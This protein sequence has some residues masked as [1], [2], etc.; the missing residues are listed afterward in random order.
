MIKEQL[1]VSAILT[2]CMTAGLAACTAENTAVQEDAPQ[3]LT[4]SVNTNG[5]GGQTRGTP[6]NAV[7]D[8][9]A[10]IGLFAYEY[11]DEDMDWDE[12]RENA[13][14]N[15]MINEELQQYGD[16]WNTVNVFEKPSKAEDI[17]NV[18]FFAYYPYDTPGLTLPTEESMG[19]PSFTYKLPELAENQID[20]MAG[21]GDEVYKTDKAVK[22]G[23]S[24]TLR[25]LLTQVT[26]EINE[27]SVK[28]KLVSISMSGVLGTNTYR[29]RKT[30]GVYDGWKVLDFDDD[31]VRDLL[32]TVSQPLNL[33][34][35]T[36]QSRTVTDPETS[37]TSITQVKLPAEATFFMLPHTLPDK[38][39]L[40]LVFNSDGEDREIKAS[41]AGRTWK[42]ASHVV[43]TI[44]I[45]SLKMMTI[46]SKLN[47]WD[48]NTQITADNASD[49]IT[50]KS[51]S[52]LN[53]WGE[54]TNSS[55]SEDGRTADETA[56]Y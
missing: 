4:F 21:E 41:L 14:P 26:F 54:T 23:V 1:F 20:L 48:T 51:K 35:T 8:M 19:A 15:F 39:Q 22:D 24:L 10:S 16:K 53:D 55:N 49:G 2:V 28:G 34:V 27:C 11:D 31:E 9:D 5:D 17:Q 30:E 45:N 44:D 47:G 25:H 13:Y 7:A 42:T 56:N 43:Y 33:S 6:V 12:G 36:T 32:T 18:R 40:T 38:A 50:I 37:T 52:S 46:K 29:M 3:P